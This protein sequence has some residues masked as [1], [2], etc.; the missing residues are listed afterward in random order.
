MTGL[1]AA[2][3]GECES[4]GAKT[5][6]GPWSDEQ[7]ADVVDNLGTSIEEFGDFCDECLVKE[8]GRGDIAYTER[9]LRRPMAVTPKPTGLL[10]LIDNYRKGH[11]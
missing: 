1:E 3:R 4:C 10:A 11:Q 5:H 6:H 9:L 2:K 8:I 7:I